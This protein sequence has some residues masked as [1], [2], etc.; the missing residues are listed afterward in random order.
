MAVDQDPSIMSPERKA[1]PGPIG[2]P[3]V[4]PFGFLRGVPEP[5]RALVGDMQKGRPPVLK[6]T[7]TRK[8]RRYP[9]TIGSTRYPPFKG[10]FF[11]LEGSFG[12]SSSPKLRGLCW[13]HVRAHRPEQGGDRCRKPQTGQTGQ[14]GQTERESEVF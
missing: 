1:K 7:A 2:G 11:S 3:C 12:P 8:K 4:V 10:F 13:L 14:T 9:P 6:G 5:T